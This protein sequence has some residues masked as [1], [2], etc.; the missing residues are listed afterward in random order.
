MKS[1]RRR[2]SS[3]DNVGPNVFNRRSTTLVRAEAAV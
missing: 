1:A 3:L 2:F